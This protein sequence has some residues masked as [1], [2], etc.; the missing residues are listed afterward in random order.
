MKIRHQQVAGY[1]YPAEKEK[2]QHDISLLLNVTKSEKSFKKIFG[3]VSPHAGYIYSGKTAAYVYNLL[4]DKSYNTVIIISPSH[5]E[6][7][8]GISIYD[9]DAYE[10]PLGIVEIDQIMTDELDY[11]PRNSRTSK[12]PCI[13]SSNSISSIGIERLSDCS[14]CNG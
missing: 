12:G 10:T 4:K 5:A 1:F 6:Y 7:F 3:I 2:L 14:N 8:P 13:R 9:G 11:F